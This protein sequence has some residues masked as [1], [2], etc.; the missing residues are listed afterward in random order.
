MT[1]EETIIGI[2]IS[3][4]NTIDLINGLIR[5]EMIYN[6]N[7]RFIFDAINEMNNK[8]FSVN[9]TTVIDKI[10]KTGKIDE[11][12]GAYYISSLTNVSI[13]RKA[14]IDNYCQ[15][16]TQDYIRRQMIELLSNNLETTKDTMQDIFDIY[17][18]TVSKLDK[19]FD[20]SKNEVKTLGQIMSDRIEE[21]EKRQP[22]ELLGIN[23]GH[24]VL[25]SITT[26]FQPGDFIILAARPSMGKTAISLALAKYPSLI[27]NKTVLYF[28]LEMPA[29]RLADR[30]I[31][32]DTS[33][34]SRNIQSN[35][36][37]QSERS[38]IYDVIDRY[39]NANFLI[40]DESGLTIEQ[41]KAI[42]IMES[43]KRKI[44]IIFIDYLQLIKFSLKDNKNT[45]EQI[46]HISKNIKALAKKLNIPIVALSQL[47]RSVET[48]SGDKRP[49]MSDLRD[50]GTLEQDADLIMFLNRP[51]YYGHLEDAEGN[52]TKNVIELIISKHRNG[53][54]GTTFY[55][56]NDTW[57][58]LSDKP[59]GYFVSEEM[60]DL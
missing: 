22:N 3:E 43:R 13:A 18:D 48:R 15:I 26:G 32:L 41:L 11:I 53:E 34:N 6:N 27:E 57:S 31:S 1:I 55:Y 35:Q 58:Y 25:N 7:C 17:S 10:R 5:S 2:M 42:S 45:N 54:I 12:G 38:A 56:K 60:P 44:D 30:V 21:I 23:T 39:H 28:S 59:F 36:L 40:N 50:S 52:S 14:D 16:I 47:N 33:I 20:V 9:M 51:E 37:N 19:L 29:E 46:G 49:M 4:S 24:S 8:G